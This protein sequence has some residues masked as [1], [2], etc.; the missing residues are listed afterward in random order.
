MKKLYSVKFLEPQRIT[1]Y[2]HATNEKEA[3]TKI[4]FQIASWLAM[5]DNVEVSFIEN[6]PD[7]K[8]LIVPSSGGIQ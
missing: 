4:R 3:E 6:V 2:V 7:E 1:F 5:P 8:K